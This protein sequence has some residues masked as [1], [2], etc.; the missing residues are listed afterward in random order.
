LDFQFLKT[1]SVLVKEFKGHR[2]V[3]TKIL[4]FYADFKIGSSKLL[5]KDRKKTV[6]RPTLFWV[7]CVTKASL[8]F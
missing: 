6:F 7:H 3:Y 4:I 8:N 2:S 1:K 5:E